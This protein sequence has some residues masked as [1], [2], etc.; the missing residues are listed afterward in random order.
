[1]KENLDRCSMLLD[2]FLQC[3]IAPTVRVVVYQDEPQGRPFCDICAA[4]LQK[5]G[6]TNMKKL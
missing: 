4:K 3:L 5:V 2:N 6:F 1:M